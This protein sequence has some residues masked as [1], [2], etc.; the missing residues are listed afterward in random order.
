ME[1]KIQ[2]TGFQ[3]I[4]ETAALCLGI[5]NAFVPGIGVASPIGIVG[6]SLLTSS[7]NADTNKPPEG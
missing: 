6:V 3:K 2:K 5:A 7:Q 1:P 4:F